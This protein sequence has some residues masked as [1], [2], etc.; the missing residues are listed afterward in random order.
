L[1]VPAAQAGSLK[2]FFRVIEG[3]ERNPAVLKKV[4]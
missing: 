1:S 3:D 4:P 2:K